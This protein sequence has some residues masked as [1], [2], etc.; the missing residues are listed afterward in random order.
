MRTR[1]LVAGTAISTLILGATSLQLLIPASASAPAAANA[2]SAARFLRVGSFN[3]SGVNNDSSAHPN[4]RWRARR[5]VV[6]RQILTRHLDVIGLQEANQSTIYKNRLAN[7]KTQYLDVL[8]GLNAHGA[9]YRLTSRA[10]YNCVRAFSSRNCVARD[11]NASGDDR[12]VY[13]DSKLALV[14]A[15][16][17]EYGSHTG[18]IKRYLAWAVLRKRSTGRR[19]LFTDTHLNPYSHASR[20]AEWRQMI[21]KINSLKGSMP[22][23]S[24]GD[25]NTSKYSPWASSMLPAMRNAGYGDVLGQHYR[26]NPPRHVRA[27]SLARAWVNSFNEYRRSV[28]KYSYYRNRHKVGNGIDWIFA[29]RS[30]T[31]RGFAVVVSMNPHTLRLRGTIPS[32]HNLIRATIVL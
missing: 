17:Y 4:R 20:I 24:V 28:K 7:G 23:V 21:G 11:R 8:N 6:V 12:I 19:F 2:T 29:S 18:G 26:V 3:I 30:L 16:S 5:P 14:R 22:V 10:A 27:H 13:N 25:F 32:D 15:G 9:H 1:A 31:V